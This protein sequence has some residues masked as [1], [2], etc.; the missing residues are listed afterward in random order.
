MG[1][2]TAVTIV[3]I[4]NDTRKG[5][6]NKEYRMV[7]LRSPTVRKLEGKLKLLFPG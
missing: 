1:I 6:T 4:K 7:R 3:K 2:K 5:R